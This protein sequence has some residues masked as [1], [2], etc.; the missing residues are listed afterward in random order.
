MPYPLPSTK[1]LQKEQSCIRMFFIDFSLLSFHRSHAL[2]SQGQ[3]SVC[4]CASFYN[5]LCIFPLCESKDRFYTLRIYLHHN[6]ANTTQWETPH[7][8]NA[9]YIRHPQH[10]EESMCPESIRAIS[11]LMKPN[12]ILM[13]RWKELSFFFFFADLVKIIHAFIS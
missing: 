1:S 3:K 7:R 10:H 2:Y 4:H 5:K 13:N 8:L 6:I 11:Q 9:S 12:W